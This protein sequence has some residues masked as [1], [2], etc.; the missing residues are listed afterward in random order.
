RESGTAVRVSRRVVYIWPPTFSSTISG[1]EEEEVEE[2]VEEG[3]WLSLSAI[4]DRRWS[5]GGAQVV[6][7]GSSGGVQGELGWSPGGAQGVQ[8]AGC[9]GTTPEFIV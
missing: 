4:S 8:T 5:P 1:K 2:E 9:G 6:S 3:T 7:R